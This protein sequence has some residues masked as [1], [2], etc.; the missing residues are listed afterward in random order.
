MMR[1]LRLLLRWLEIWNRRAANST[2]AF[3]PDVE[4][5]LRDKLIKHKTDINKYADCDNDEVSVKVSH[6]LFTRH[7]QLYRLEELSRLHQVHQKLTNEYNEKDDTFTQP[8]S[9]IPYQSF[10][11]GYGRYEP[12]RRTHPEERIYR[13]AATDLFVEKAQAFL[14]QRAESYQRTGKIAHIVACVI[15]FIGA[16]FACQQMMS[17]HGEHAKSW[18]ALLTTFTRAFTAYGMIVLAAVGLWRYGKA[19]LDQSE[20]LYERRHALRQGRL[21]VHLN[22]G[23]LDIEELER[24]FK[25]NE[26]Q[27]NAFANIHTEA[28]APWGAVMK[29]L[30]KSF[31]EVVKA[32][33]QNIS[34]GKNED[35]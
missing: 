22:D 18:L 9:S 28:S 11:P 19:M 8:A 16:F 31:P 34:K 27:E 14:E 23:K 20:R 30:A 17:L 29:E 3:A 1:L 5:E 4:K 6:N 7:M 15:I 10:F 33:L 32:G 13:L 26:S 25:W 35:K 2:P 12:P 21:F 24:A